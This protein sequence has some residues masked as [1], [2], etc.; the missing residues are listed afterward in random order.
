MDHVLRGSKYSNS[1]LNISAFLQDFDSFESKIIWIKYLKLGYLILQPTKAILIFKLHRRAN[2]GWFYCL[3]I[4]LQAFSARKLDPNKWIV[5]VDMK[6][7]SVH[8]SNSLG[9]AFYLNNA[10]K[11]VDNGNNWKPKYLILTCTSKTFWS[12]KLLQIK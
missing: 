2:D 11:S 12:F 5:F 10:I 6:Q 7:F 4:N 8:K 3:R 1:T 9:I